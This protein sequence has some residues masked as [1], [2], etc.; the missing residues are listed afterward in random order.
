[1]DCTRIDLDSSASCPPITPDQ[2]GAEGA[3]T[4][5]DFDTYNDFTIENCDVSM[6]HGTGISQDWYLASTLE[7]DHWNGATHD[8]HGCTM[9]SGT[10]N[11]ND[12]DLACSLEQHQIIDQGGQEQSL[13]SAS[14]IEPGLSPFADEQLSTQPID[15]FASYLNS[16]QD[17]I[18]ASTLEDFSGLNQQSSGVRP[19]ITGTGT[20]SGPIRDMSTINVKPP[21]TSPLGNTHNF[22]ESC[23]RSTP[24]TSTKKKRARISDAAKKI[25]NEHF[26]I[27]PYP[28]EMETS[29]LE[30]TTQLT[31]RTIKT[32]FSN[33][34]S[35]KKVMDTTPCT[36]S[37]DVISRASLEALE[38]MSPASSMESLQ[39]YLALPSSEEPARLEAIIAG[40]ERAAMDIR[41]SSGGHGDV[42][43]PPERPSV[44][45]RG[46]STRPGSVAGSDSSRGSAKSHTSQKSFRSVDS[47]GSRRGRKLWKRSQ[48][49]S[50]GDAQAER[51]TITASATNAPKVVATHIKNRAP[52]YYCTW[53]TCIARFQFRSEW[54]R[55][56]EAVH[57]QPYQWICC[58][59]ET[60]EEE[61]GQCFICGQSNVIF[62]H[63][64]TE[65]FTSCVGKDETERTFYRRDQLIQHIKGSHSFDTS[66]LHGEYALTDL[67]CHWEV[68]SPPS[69]DIRTLTCGVCGITCKT[70]KA[71][72]DHVFQ[73]L[74]SGICKQSWWP[75]RKRVPR[76]RR[77]VD[78]HVPGPCRNCGIH[79]NSV[80]EVC[81]FHTSCVAWSCRFLHDWHAIY[82]MTG[83]ET[84]NRLAFTCQLC[85]FTIRSTND[86][87]TA[88]L[89]EHAKSHNL[90]SC[91]QHRFADLRSFANHLEVEHNAVWKMKPIITVQ[92]WKCTQK[93]RSTTEG[94]IA[95]TTQMFQ[96]SVLCASTDS[97][98]HDDVH[99]LAAHVISP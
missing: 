6:P 31:G 92:P 42:H 56:E 84:R 12:W 59:E 64:A 97:P 94:P 17:F 99:G 5:F 14:W 15:Q 41:L 62:G 47:R 86:D 11:K 52:P 65:H 96:K 76:I 83:S 13:V 32:W 79:Y 53:S 44:S 91:A 4:F 55:H 72:Q 37:N 29:A 88:I 66:D 10:G 2:L 89:E 74:R 67:A 90:R 20:N 82:T 58:L 35:R 87:Y 70:W 8:Y 71:R 51:G 73:H 19:S 75:E 24:I 98:F 54:T 22:T 36:L 16:T 60:F 38:N 27:N 57:Y 3:S 25:L 48:A 45:R 26:G 95:I 78:E 39:R 23:Q 28:S 46:S 49:P 7:R 85:N 30:T 9:P 18:R 21:P 61:F 80:T 1:M 43:Q 81:K 34:R 69:P 68:S 93:I 50:S 63:I 40:N 33:N 77:L